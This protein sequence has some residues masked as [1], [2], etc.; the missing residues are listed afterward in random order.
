MCD[1]QVSCC[2][3]LS[4]PVVISVEELGLYT[5]I[6]HPLGSPPLLSGMTSYQ[7]LLPPSPA[8]NRFTQRW[9]AAPQML[10]LAHIGL[11][12]GG[13]EPETHRSPRRTLYQLSYAD[14]Y[15]YIYIYIYI[16]PQ[17]LRSRGRG[18]QISYYYDFKSI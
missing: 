18:D 7:L 15:I 13:R 17:N 4:L 9:L 11:A 12:G 5:Y 8:V 3:L 6:Y 14:I 2:Y 1:L 16:F 10:Y